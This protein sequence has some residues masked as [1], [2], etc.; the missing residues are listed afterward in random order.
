MTKSTT[1][2]GFMRQTFLLSEVLVVDHRND[3]ADWFSA[4]N[5]LEKSCRFRY[6]LQIIRNVVLLCVS[7]CAQGKAGS[8]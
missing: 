8:N 4:T 3:F 2:A 5:K 1:F 6:T 7:V